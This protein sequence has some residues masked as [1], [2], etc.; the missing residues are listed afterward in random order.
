MTWLN[1]IQKT[2][3]PG[4]IVSV[5]SA[6]IFLLLPGCLALMLGLNG[7]GGTAFGVV[8]I[9][10][11]LGVLFIV[12]SKPNARR[13]RALF[14]E[15]VDSLGERSVVLGAIE[16]TPRDQGFS[17]YDV[18]LHPLFFAFRFEN[19]A[20]IWQAD[21]IAWIYIE[22]NHTTNKD[23]LVGITIAKSTTINFFLKVCCVDRKSFSFILKSKQE[24]LD[25]IARL[26]ARYPHA[27]FGYSAQSAQA[28]NADPRR[29]IR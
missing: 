23:K 3:V 21:S 20:H 29:L 16:A 17:A 6:S 18:R 19:V 1:E 25:L 11:Y 2:S 12:F 13:N 9:L 4:V 7:S 24:G 5:V 15:E 10:L 27:T 22:E 14:L 8:L 26:Q 28:Y